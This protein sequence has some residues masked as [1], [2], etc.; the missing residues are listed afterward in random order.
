MID[1]RQ[2]LIAVFEDTQ[3]FCRE[4]PV[5]AEAVKASQK[6][7]VLYEPDDE[8]PLPRTPHATACV[9]V[10]R[11]TSF[12]AARDRAARFA[13][14]RIA[15]L[16]FASAVNPGGGVKKGSRAQEESLC[17]CS[18]LYPT[19]DQ[20]FLWERYYTPNR[21]AADPLHSDACIWSPGIV[22]CKTDGGLPQ[23]MPPEEWTTVDV[24]SC[25][26]PNLREQTDNVYNPEAAAPVRLSPDEQYALHLKRAGH[27]LRIAASRQADALILGAFGCGAFAN[28]PHAVAKACRDAVDA[29][30]RYFRY[31][32]FAVYCSPRD[33]RNFKIFERVLKTYCGYW[34]FT[35]TSD[36]LL[37]CRKLGAFAPGAWKFGYTCSIFIGSEVLYVG[38]HVKG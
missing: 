28:D 8:P 20:P 33:E 17:R 1:R 31:I 27:I 2:Q 19:L 38:T 3:R 16:N 22:I 23:R 14:E 18:T 25:A 35:F 29:Y 26:A 12:Q 36:H 11:S 6:G 30:G 32:E 15:V 7:T 5:L 24:I 9:A 21:R 34:F 13:G 4:N 37:V 10:T